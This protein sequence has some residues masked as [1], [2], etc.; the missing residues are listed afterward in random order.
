M[1]EIAETTEGTETKP[2]ET[3]TETKV[4]TGGEE[5]Q[6]S[7]EAV[8]M[9]EE[10]I[11]PAA[12]ASESEE[13][14]QDDNEVIASW[15]SGKVPPATPAADTGEEP[16]PAV[17]EKLQSEV[18][19]LRKENE[20]LKTELTSLR[21][22]KSDPFVA[23]WLAHQDAHG[24]EASVKTFLAQVGAVKQ[25]NADNEQDVLAQYFRSKAIEIGTPEDELETAVLEEMESYNT[26]STIG[27][28]TLL[29]TATDAVKKGGVDSIEKLQEEYTKTVEE[30]R[31]EF[32]TWAVAQRE[33]LVDLVNVFAEKGRF[34]GRKI[35]G[36]EWKSSVLAVADVSTDILNPAFGFYDTEGNLDAPKVLKYLDRVANGDKIEEN[37]R[38]GLQKKAKENLT[39]RAEAAHQASIAAEIV[40]T[41]S[42]EQEK[43]KI[44]EALKRANGGQ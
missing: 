43:A 22:L 8:E 28:R 35:E 11:E 33:T 2:A 32:G 23:A 27:K 5:A 42:E 15:K 26:L 18:V 31:K 34:S 10:V 4:D 12:A 39:E 16:A 3:V 14:E 6:A 24:S 40:N 20:D 19:A 21:S 38:N 36:K 41:P 1:A 37:Y 7:A 30:R 44:R 17:D 13:E 29:K 9:E 25:F